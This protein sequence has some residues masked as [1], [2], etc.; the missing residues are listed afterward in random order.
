MCHF[1]AVGPISDLKREISYQL[2]EWSLPRLTV[3]YIFF[4]FLGCQI[5]EHSMPHLL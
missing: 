3:L 5:H 2:T 1:I 4:S